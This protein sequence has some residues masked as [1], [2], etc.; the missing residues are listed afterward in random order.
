MHN[1]VGKRH[2]GVEQKAR[3]IFREPPGFKPKK[4]RN[5]YG[6]CALLGSTISTGSNTKAWRKILFILYCEQV[7][8]K[9]ETEF[10]NKIVL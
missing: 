9:T 2:I 1:E 5:P 3:Q 4:P 6:T 8:S 7:L 10:Q